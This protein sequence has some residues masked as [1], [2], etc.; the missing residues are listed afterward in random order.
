M[1]EQT[2]LGYTII[3]AAVPKLSGDKKV[4]EKVKKYLDY[5]KERDG[6]WIRV[7]RVLRIPVNQSAGRY[8]SKFYT[9]LRDNAKLW[10][11]KCP[12]C[13]RIIFPP[14]ISCG[15]CKIK[16]ED[17]EEN[18][19]EL[20]PKGTLIM[21]SVDVEK[22]RDWV[23]TKEIGYNNPRA[24]IRLDGGDKYTYIEHLL[25]EGV[26]DKVMKGIV[27]EGTIVEAVFRPREE[28]KGTIEDIEYFRI[29]EGQ[30][31]EI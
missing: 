23:T 16:I 5:I 30:K 11:N 3:Q 29:I 6:N 24:T 7:E 15:K 31:E 12:E 13:K 1:A 4:M 9:E 18:W 27:K 20:S 10:A 17:K 26:A 2:D 19:V 25:E 21:A 8:L 22:E 28:R 14:R